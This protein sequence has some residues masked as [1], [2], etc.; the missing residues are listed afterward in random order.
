MAAQADLGTITADVLK[1]P[2]H[3]GATSSLSW[4]AAVDPASRGGER[5]GQ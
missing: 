3:G 4:L 5:R 2:H 1:V